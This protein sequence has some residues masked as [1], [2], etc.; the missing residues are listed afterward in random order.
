MGAAARSLRRRGPVVRLDV[1]LRYER[2][3]RGRLVKTEDEILHTPGCRGC[4]EQ[5]PSVAVDRKERLISEVM[6]RGLAH[7][8]GYGTMSSTLH[9]GVPGFHLGS[10]ASS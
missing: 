10:S 6:P 8:S 1:G 5:S 9:R 2:D 3:D 4:R 7:R